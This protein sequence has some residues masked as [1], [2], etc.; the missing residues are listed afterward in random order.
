M[1]MSLWSWITR[2]R[3]GLDE[4]DFQDEIRAHLAI[5]ADEQIAGGA[6][7][8][9]ARHASLR[10]FG[11]V[12]LTTE[13]A[14]G[15]WRPRWL[16]L[17]RD[18]RN[19]VRYAL[20]ALAKHRA[21]SLT[22]IGVL[23]L[24]IG[25]NAAVF[26]ML[27]SMAFSP[28]AGVRGSAHLHS[29]FVETSAGRA[30]GFSYP[31][32]QYFRDHDQAFSGTYCSILAA[33]G[34]GRG[35]ESR[36]VWSELVTGAYFQVL[37]V[38]AEQGRTLLPSD[39]VAPGR[40]PV[41]VISDG[42]WRRDFGA[43]P[44]IVGKTITFN[45]TPLTVV[46]VADPAFHGTTVVYDVEAYLPVMM[47][48]QLGITLGSRA[49]TPAGV[50][51]DRSV[52]I[53]SPEGYLRPGMTSARATTQVGAL[54]SAWSRER[55]SSDPE[56]RMR[57]VPY[58]QAPN[59]AQSIILPT[60]LVI[61]AMGLLVLSIACSNIAGLVIVRGL[62]RRGEIA[63]R[64]AL[65]AA[66][67]RIVRLLVVENLVLAV[68][69]TLFGVLLASHGIPVLVGYAEQIA[70]PQRLFFNVQVDGL[71]IGFA[72]AVACGSAL[73][74]G[75]LPALQ[76]S[77]IDLVSVMNETSSR[78][79][80]RGRLRRALVVAQVAVSLL[81]LVGAGLVT[82]SLDAARRA[83]P[84]FDPSHVAATA[85]DVRQVGYGEPRGRAFY[86]RLL[87]TMRS[88]PTT[89]SVTI[90][91]WVPLYVLATPAMRLDIEGYEPH[92]GEDLAFLFNAVGPDYL[93]TLR[94]PVLAG[95]D[96]D[97]HDDEA[98]APVALV[99]RTFAE[100]FWGSASNAPGRRIRTA[101]GEWRT[102]VGVAADLKYLQ[103]NERPRPYVYL[104]IFQAYRPA[105]VMQ[106]RGEASDV[107]LAER[108]HAA[109]A[110]LNP[111]LPM[112]VRPMRERI[113]GALI[114]MSLAATMLSIFGLTGMVL[115]AMGTY[116]L[117]AYIVK[118]STRE[119]GIRMALGASR[120]SIVRAFLGRGVRLGAVGVTVGI[121]AALG[122]MRVLR[123]VLFGVSATD[124]ATYAQALAIVLTG[125]V[126][127]TL[128]PVWRAAQI[129][130]LRAL[131]RD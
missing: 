36:G 56:T 101:D 103:L 63:M 100:R 95:R 72:V 32:Y 16:D 114:F 34:L 29:A 77:R 126:L 24:G 61:A 86:R 125:V 9:S 57:V 75:F 64:L 113:N 67:A 118:Q 33:V 115:A 131:R 108:A 69:G 82:R 19:D 3:L 62:S 127:A 102:V 111:D 58:W 27:K 47:A 10:E 74:F 85:L 28:V 49:A 59:S 11:N 4:Q 60:L 90:S 91:A 76:S 65:G 50:F 81:L 18:L 66:R 124:P 104:P 117:V 44:A 73:A 88:D 78:G 21:F 109:V 8:A 42:L 106:S 14:R 17:L 46:G 5:A 35:K 31:D 130:P 13:A 23:T 53:F 48:P 94:V 25:L 92:T 6:D 38:R 87:E 30:M 93:R 37:G 123:S 121:L 1:S 98:S 99:N 122:V 70:A 2:R 20:R 26:T 43:D 71:V 96:F 112:F 40:H 7:R 128:L 52:T 116:G 97:D 39:E 129:D 119:I 45:N 12:A 55:P 105:V 89:E 68:P 22:V 80:V 41:V 84:G 79:S 15:V 120:L 110:A 51:D 83:N 107:V 54:W